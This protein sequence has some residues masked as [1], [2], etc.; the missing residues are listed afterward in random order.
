MDS[1]L[2]DEVNVEVAEYLK[3]WG[4]SQSTIAHFEENQISF[5][6]LDHIQETELDEL[7][8]SLKERLF[9]RGLNKLQ[10]IIHML[11]TSVTA[12]QLVLKL[13]RLIKVKSLPN[14]NIGKKPKQLKVSKAPQ[15]YYGV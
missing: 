13:F 5:P 3:E 7:I 8:P 10:N 12:H 15:S 9:K 1:D 2:E 11:E 14:W 6:L 4:L